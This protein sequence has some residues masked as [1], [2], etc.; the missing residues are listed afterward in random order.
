VGD[1]KGARPTLTNDMIR[2]LKLSGNPEAG[3]KA[4]EIMQKQGDEYD[5]RARLA[6]NAALV[7]QVRSFSVEVL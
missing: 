4:L 5:I 7:S 2:S 3:F 1:D 6:A